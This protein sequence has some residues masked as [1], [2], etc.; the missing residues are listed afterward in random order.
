MAKVDGEDDLATICGGGCVDEMVDCSTE[1][2]GTGAP[3][4]SI[5]K[6]CHKKN[7]V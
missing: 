4:L 7:A 3:R 6:L 5:A 1:L 2:V